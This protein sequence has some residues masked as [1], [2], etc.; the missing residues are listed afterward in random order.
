MTGPLP[1]ATAPTPAQIPTAVPRWRAGN[2]D[3]ASPSEVGSNTA[4][5]TACS[6]R[7]AIKT[8]RAG[9]TAHPSEARP[10]MTRPARKQPRRPM[11][12]ATR[13]PGSSRAASTIAYASRIHETSDSVAGAKSC[14]STGS[15]ILTT[16]RSRMMTN[17]AADTTASTPHRRLV[18]R[19]ACA[20]ASAPASPGAFEPARMLADELMGPATGSVE[21]RSSAEGRK[22]GVRSAFEGCVRAGP[23][24]ERPPGPP[25]RPAGAAAPSV[26]AAMNRG[27]RDGLPSEDTDRRSDD[28]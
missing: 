14:R 28:E 25:G 8:G 12:S 19:P 2:A 24:G 17:W 18:S 22:Q 10:K 6:A 13:P 7:P 1:A 26:R 9:A 21:I 23:S 5:P 15:A 20:G 27:R 16:Q 4:A 11:V 3:R